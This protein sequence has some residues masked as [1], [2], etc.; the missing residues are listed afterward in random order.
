[1]WQRKYKDYKYGRCFYSSAFHTDMPD[2]LACF[3]PIGRN[4][5]IAKEKVNTFR[6]YMMFSLRML[7]SWFSPCKPPRMAPRD[8]T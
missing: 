6:H 1:M 8:H 4:D 2:C 5:D 7:R 3:L